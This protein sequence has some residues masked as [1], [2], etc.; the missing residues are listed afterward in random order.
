[1]TVSI[2]KPNPIIVNN[3]K[4]DSV[5]LFFDKIKQNVIRLEIISARNQYELYTLI[6]PIK[7]EY[8]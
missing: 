1:M 6:T 3:R 5:F 2:I 8:I 7:R 4:R